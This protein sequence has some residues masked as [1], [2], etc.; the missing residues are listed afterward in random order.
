MLSG[1]VGSRVGKHRSQNQ[2]TFAEEEERN[3]G[4]ST[5][6]LLHPFLQ[7]STSASFTEK[8]DTHR[9]AL[10]LA[11]KSPSSTTSNYL[12]GGLGGSHGGGSLAQTYYSGTSLSEDAALDL[13]LEYL[14][15]KKLNIAKHALIKEIRAERERAAIPAPCYRGL[16]TLEEKSDKNGRHSAPKVQSKLEKLMKKAAEKSIP[17]QNAEESSNCKETSEKLSTKNKSSTRR[18]PN[19]DPYGA[20]SMPIYQ[21]ATFEIDELNPYDYS[22]SGNPTRSAF[23]DA[24]SQLENAEA[25]FAFTSG[26]SALST[27]CHL[28]K[29]DERILCSDDSYGGLYRVLDKVSRAQG[30]SVD[31]LTLDGLSGP[32]NLRKEFANVNKEDNKSGGEKEKKRIGMVFIESPTNPQ[33]RICDIRKLAHICHENGAL[34]CIDNTMLSPILQR[35]FCLDLEDETNNADLIVHSATKFISGHA[36]AMGGV[37][38]CRTEE[39]SRRIYFLQNA[40]GNGIAPFSAWLLLRGMKTI[41]MRVLEQQRNAE[42]IAKY[43]HS[44]P[45]VTKVYYANLPSHPGY[46][47]HVNQSDGGGSV[48]AF[49]TGSMKLSTYLLKATKLFKVTVSFGSVNSLIEMPCTMSHASIPS[50]VRAS[51]AFPEDLL[52]LSIGIEAVNDLIDDLENAFTS[53]QNQ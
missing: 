25:S 17:Q 23:Q 31:F 44:H 46:D 47:I 14:E 27:V 13:V 29:A 16:P 37:V 51:R 22:R 19:H 32:E 42:Q 36:D 18:S 21:T 38:C 15:K 8:A 34:L 33:M 39:L 5:A 10:D 26:M 24:V 4:T 3:S 35:P 53:F 49:L 1:S 20:S 48:I 9:S 7:K 41:A 12:G 11:T 30:I 45:L 28:V 43:L 52:R 6:F 40:E 2:E 50:E